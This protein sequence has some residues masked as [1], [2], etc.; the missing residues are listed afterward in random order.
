MKTRIFSILVV[1][2]ATISCGTDNKAKATGEKDFYTVE[3]SSGS[4]LVYTFD[5]NKSTM[6]IVFGDIKE[7]LIQQRAASGFW[8]AN[9]H[10]EVR[11]KGDEIELTK[12][13]ELLFKSRDK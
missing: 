1:V 4:I 11:G 3:D 9:N 2:F 5:K 6:T 7:E 8:Y 13:G 10:Y 12:D